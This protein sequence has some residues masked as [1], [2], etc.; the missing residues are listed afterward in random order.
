ME[1]EKRWQSGSQGTMLSVQ[2]A[3]RRKTLS[4]VIEHSE[5]LSQNGSGC[6][7]GRPR[8]SQ[9]VFLKEEVLG[10]RQTQTGVRI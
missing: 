9:N 3:C 4:S 2:S 8:E 5:L 10:Y 7:N 1:T 6:S